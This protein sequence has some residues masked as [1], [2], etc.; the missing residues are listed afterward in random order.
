MSDIAVPPPV[1]VERHG[2]VMVITINRPDARNAVNQAVW[3]G[4]GDAL[5]AADRDID[6]RVVIVT[7][8]GDQSF[9]AGA[10]L[11]AIS[12]GE[13]ILPSDPEKAAW[14]FAGIVSHVVSK[15]L[16]AAVNGTA[17]GGGTEIALAC[18]LVVAADTATFGL[19]EVK[20]GLLAGAGGAFR[21]KQQLPAKIAMEMLL[22]GDAIS[23]ARA[24]DLGLVNQVVPRAELMAAALKLAER[25]TVNAPL[26]V[27]ASKRIALGIRDGKIASDAAGWAITVHETPGV[28][29]SAD[30][31]EGPRAFAEKRAPVWKGI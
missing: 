17:L 16:I 5:A 20:R 6:V 24:L 29:G 8:A 19:P 10:D 18:D 15:P 9:C 26:S 11:K 31:R 14:G 4:V 2:H 1:L 12:R 25:I 27:Q 13:S 30:A 23:A 7:G 21:L 22:T 28:M 3:S